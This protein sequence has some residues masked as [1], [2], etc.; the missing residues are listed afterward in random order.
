MLAFWHDEQRVLEVCF[1][2]G[3]LGEP[4]LVEGLA[5]DAACEVSVEL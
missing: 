3:G 4:Y 5:G 2:G 1:A